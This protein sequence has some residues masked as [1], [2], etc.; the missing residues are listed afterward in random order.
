M[1]TGGL[2]FGAHLARHGRRR[3]KRGT[4]IVPP[5]PYN[6]AM[7]IVINGQRVEDEVLNAE[8]SNIKSYFESLGNVSCCER[9]PE[10]RGYARE[11]VVARVLLSQEAR[12]A[13]P[14]VP[15]D[16][17][18]AALDKLKEENGG[19]Q[20]FLMMIGAAP[21]QLDLVRRDLEAD[22]RVRKMLDRLLAED[23]EPS[24][25][26]LRSYYEQ[27]I[28][29]FKTPEEVRASH[30][31]KASRGEQRHESYELLRDLRRQ[32]QAGAAFE[33]LARAHSDKGDEHIDLG[34]FKRGELAEEFEIVA[35]SL[36]IGEVSPIFATP[37]GYH[38]IQLTDRKPATPKPFDEVRAEVRD[39]LLAQLKQEKT[40][41]LVKHLQAAATIEDVEDPALTAAE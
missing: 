12:R 18:E 32:L 3:T 9:D 19:E 15:A 7:A 23:P 35:F 10:F 14:P 6:P 39:Q 24:D 34:F 37:F 20:R 4:A 26:D 5:A 8:F 36:N 33:P 25:A 31:L 17:V 22:L 2:F 21:D 1:T 41:E 29:R 28:D 30:I 11:N 40:R 27:H 13:M 38:L 16:E